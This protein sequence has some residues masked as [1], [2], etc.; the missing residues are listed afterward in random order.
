MN[1]V[2][3]DD[4]E[5][6]RDVL[7]AILRENGIEVRTA[8][9]GRKGLDMLAET[10]TDFL[11]TDF[12]MPHMN[13]TELLKQAQCLSPQTKVILISGHVDFDGAIAKAAQGA[14]AT[15]NKPFDFRT[16]MDLLSAPDTQA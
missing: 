10:P 16:L 13:G 11:I 8:E 15:L 6:V 14:Y 2:I 5:V 7:A 1:V 9:S 12:L 4:E 3:V